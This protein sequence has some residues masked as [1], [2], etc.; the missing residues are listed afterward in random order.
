MIAYIEY[1]GIPDVDLGPDIYT[2]RPDTVVLDAGSGFMSYVWY[3]GQNGQTYN[4]LDIGWKWVFVTDIYG[5]IG[6]DTIYVGLY[7]H[8][9]G[10][11]ELF[12]SKIY[13]NPAKEQVTVDV[14]T[15]IPFNTIELEIIDIRGNIVRSEKI[16]GHGTSR[17]TLD[18]S[19]LQPGVYF[20]QLRR[21]NYIET[22]KLTIIH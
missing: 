10:M 13:P 1:A 2:G 9:S 19:F 5:C 18:V 14:S 12:T 20:I 6:S 16:S 7:T 3:D 11:D 15:D 21:N 22:H 8:I 4:V 17:K